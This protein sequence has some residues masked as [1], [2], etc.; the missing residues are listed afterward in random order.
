MLLI[1]LV[2][3]GNLLW[4]TG[5]HYL[6]VCAC[7][8]WRFSLVILDLAIHEDQKEVS[9]RHV[10]KNTRHTRKTTLK[11]D[12]N[13]IRPYRCLQDS[14]VQINLIKRKLHETASTFEHGIWGSLNLCSRAMVPQNSSRINYLLKTR[15]MIYTY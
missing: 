5:H 10:H 14:I 2:N 13:M 8:S 12:S 7:V 3:V 4:H 11:G 9:V 1:A 6:K 15:A